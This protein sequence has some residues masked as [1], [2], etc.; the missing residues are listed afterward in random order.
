MLRQ[1]VAQLAGAD[2][3]DA[4]VFR[5]AVVKWPALVVHDPM[6]VSQ[7]REAHA[8]LGMGM[9]DAADVGTRGVDAGV[10]PAFAV[11][12]ALAREELAI[13]VQDQQMILV[14]EAR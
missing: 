11:R 10:D 2:Q 13:G 3:P 7:L 6:R 8:S 9:D 1:Q 12:R 5:H 14:R 4:V